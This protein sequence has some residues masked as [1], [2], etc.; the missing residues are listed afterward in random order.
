MFFERVAI[1]SAMALTTLAQSAMA[2]PSVCVVYTVVEFAFPI[3]ACFTVNTVISIES[4]TPVSVTNAPTCITTVVTASTTLSLSNPEWNS[5]T[6]LLESI[7][8]TNKLAIILPIT[9]DTP[10]IA[11]LRPSIISPPAV[12]T[13]TATIESP[14]TVTSSTPSTSACNIAPPMETQPGTTPYCCEWYVVQPGDTCDSITTTVDIA[15]GTIYELNPELLA[16]C[17]NLALGYAYCVSG[18]PQNV[19]P[20]ALFY[21]VAKDS[22]TA[23]D[24][25]TLMGGHSDHAIMGFNL[26]W[27]EEPLSFTYDADTGFLESEGYFVY[28]ISLSGLGPLMLVTYTPLDGMN[29]PGAYPLVCTVTLGPK[30]YCEVDGGAHDRLYLFNY[31]GHLGLGLSDGTGV[32]IAAVDLFLESA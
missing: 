15:A 20:P 9:S 6:T 28:A 5:A 29:T 23:A 21:I 26:P 19:P 14:S 17:Y 4:V 22:D 16:D 7:P 27:G 32:P 18:N 11:H 13:S 30:L 10:S 1:V 2:L 31:T 25:T 12:V 24:G 8:T 3:N